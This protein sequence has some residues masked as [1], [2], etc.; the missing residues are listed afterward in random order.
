M[1]NTHH[2]YDAAQ[3][4]TAC[5]IP[6]V[7]TCNTTVDASGPQIGWNARGRTYWLSYS[8]PAGEKRFE[9]TTTC[10]ACLKRS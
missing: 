7:R 5:G 10:K 1:K 4:Q 3:R 6:L 8:F 9:F 2:T